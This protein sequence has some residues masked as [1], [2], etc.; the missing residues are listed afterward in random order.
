[1]PAS[2]SPIPSELR[3]KIAPAP[4][5]F[6]AGE[7]TFVKVA[8]V[9][10]AAF[11]LYG[12]VPLNQDHN[13]F[14]Y[15]LGP[16]LCP[17]VPAAFFTLLPPLPSRGT[18]L[19]GNWRSVDRVDPVVTRLVELY[20]SRE[21]R[22]HLWS[23]SLKVSAMLFGILG[24]AAIA[25]RSNLNWALPSSQNG[26]LYQWRGPG[27]WFWYGLIGCSIF[28][29]VALVIDHVGWVTTTWAR[30][31]SALREEMGEPGDRRDVF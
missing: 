14:L 15:L 18:F 8:F 17:S 12:P 1:M 2:K 27:F 19:S 5:L 31:E 28:S 24:T 13:A 23:Q 30:R 20:K 6:G 26:F 29:F 16:W 21:A 11:C 4:L 7:R 25:Q 22:R 3:R 9:G 10:I